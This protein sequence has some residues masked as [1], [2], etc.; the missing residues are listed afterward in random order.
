MTAALSLNAPVVAI[1]GGVGGAKMALGLLHVLPHDRLTVVVNTGDDFEHLG[2]AISPDIDTALYTLGD[3]AN[4]ELG[5]GRRDETWSFMQA[6]AQLGGETWFRLGDGDLALHVER[7]RRLQQGQTLTQITRD[8]ATRFGIRAQVLPMSDAPLRTRV[9]TDQGELDF[10]DYF[11]RHQCRPRVAALR[12]AGAEQ[13]APSAQVCAALTD[14][15]LAAIIICP[16]NPYLS[17]DP[18]LALP[19]LRALLQAASAPVIAIS[20]L[21]GGTAVKGP[22]AKIM[23]ELGLDVCALTVAQHYGELLD[24]FV[25]D[26]RDAAVADDLRALDL[27][28]LVTDTLMK[29]LA[30]RQ[31]LARETLAFAATLKQAS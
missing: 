14:P 9:T 8:I 21:V 19:G 11:V 7:T 6:M 28:L 29:T 22:T 30:D 26:Q 31:R 4:L 16:S 24:G 12:F 2:L 20:P 13:A 18:I 5:W 1:S 3:L 15:Q 25:L 10:Q 23:Q 17:I 27:P